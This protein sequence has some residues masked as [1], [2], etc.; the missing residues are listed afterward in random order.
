MECAALQ[1]FN[2]FTKVFENG[3]IAVNDSIKDGIGQI[4]RTVLSE[5]CLGVLEPLVDGF[6]K[7]FAITMESALVGVQCWTGLI[8]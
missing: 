8:T 5:S 1:R 3:V 4:V 2:S 6:Q 7:F